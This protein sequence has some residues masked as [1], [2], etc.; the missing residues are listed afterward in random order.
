MDCGGRPV[1]EVPSSGLWELFLVGWLHP[2]LADVAFSS[3]K[4]SL[5]RHEGERL[6]AY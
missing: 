2:R 1:D 4:I 6:V 5:P 3:G